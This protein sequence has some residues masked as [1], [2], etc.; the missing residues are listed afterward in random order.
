[1][2]FRKYKILESRSES[3]LQTTLARREEKIAF[4]EAQVEEKASL[5]HQL[6]SELQTVR[7]GSVTTRCE[8]PGPLPQVAKRQPG[9]PLPGAGAG[10]RHLGRWQAGSRAASHMAGEV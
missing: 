9:Q 1:M 5:N 4:L 2:L 10:G 8:V 6:Q 3:V 7:A